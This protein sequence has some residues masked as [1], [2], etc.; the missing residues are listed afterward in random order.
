MLLFWLILQC[1]LSVNLLCQRVYSVLI[2]EENICR[3]LMIPTR[4]SMVSLWICRTVLLY[5]Y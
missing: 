2:E 3:D 1:K 5:L 4:M